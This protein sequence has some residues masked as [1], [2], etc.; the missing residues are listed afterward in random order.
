[1]PVQTFLRENDLSG[2]TIY[3]LV[4]HGG[5]GFG[6]A[7]EDTGKLTGADVSDINLEV[8]DE[9]VDAGSAGCS[10]LG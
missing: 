4:T 8:Y 9:D 6:T 10:F 7:I 1:M 5:S 3:S 2:K